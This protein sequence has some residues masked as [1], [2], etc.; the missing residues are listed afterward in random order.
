MP[1]YLKISLVIVLSILLLTLAFGAGCV[2]NLNQPTGGLDNTL[3]NQAWSILKEKYVVPDNV[4]DKMLNQGA[5][6]GMLESINDPYSAYLS[7]EAYKIEKSDAAGSFEGIGASVGF[8]KDRQI[9]IT[10]P[11]ENSPAEKAGI[12]SGDII[13]GV[14]GESIIG[15]SINEVVL[16]IRGPAGTPVKLTVLH[17]GEDKP[18]EIEIVR[19]AITTPSVK[20]E[21][22]GDVLYIK[23]NSFNE[24][25]N[26]EFEKALE[27]V[28]LKATSGIVL[29]LRNNPGGLVTTVVD[30]ASHFIKDGVIIT[31]RDNK[32]RTESISTN[33]NG[34][35]TELPMIVLVNEYSASG[36]EV[37]SG[38]L[39]DYQRAK[40]AGTVTFGKGS[41]D[42]FFQL[43]DG[44]AIYLTIG[45]WLTP[46]GHEIE[47][48]G[49]TPNYI[50][51]ETGEDE[52]QWAINHLKTAK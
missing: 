25:T 18:V 33:P 35:Y 29:D 46:N 52:I 11:M 20:F 34:I 9:S 13:L 15:L 17:Q 50:L 41:Y 23:I 2:I 39:Q 28:N 27:S 30:V 43:E 31:L 6:R 44:S 12:K 21:S 38:A 36:S 32:G 14:N 42:S 7:P 4:T 1:K 16:K 49:I 10:A 47:G 8:N 48:N 5:V 37:L 22:R 26:L 19:A 40:I 45:R 51:T 24:K 3:L